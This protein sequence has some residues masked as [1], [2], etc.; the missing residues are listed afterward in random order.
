MASRCP[1]CSSPSPPRGALGRFRTLCCWRAWNPCNLCTSLVPNIRMQD[2][3]TRMHLRRIQLGLPTCPSGDHAELSCQSGAQLQG[4]TNVLERNHIRGNLLVYHLLPSC[5]QAR[6]TPAT[7][8]IYYSNNSANYRTPNVNK[9]TR[10]L[11]LFK[12]KDNWI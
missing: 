1:L 10:K 11:C 2:E 7:K 4:Q 12:I 8:K 3:V 9:R 6:R 5:P